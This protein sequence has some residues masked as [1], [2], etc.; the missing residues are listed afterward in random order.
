MELLYF[1]ASPDVIIILL[2]IVSQAN[3][4]LQQAR[5]AMLKSAKEPSCNYGRK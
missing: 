4:A 2:L 5:N 1:T 3:L